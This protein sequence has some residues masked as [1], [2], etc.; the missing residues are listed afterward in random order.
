[1][2]LGGATLVALLRAAVPLAA[3]AAGGLAGCGS[4][5]VQHYYVLTPLAATA[6]ANST[7]ASTGVAIFVDQAHVP[8][9]VDR[10][11]MVIGTGENRVTILEQQRW[12]EPLRAAIAE[13]IALDLARLINGARVTAAQQI[14]IPGDAWRLSL[15]VQRFESRPG[16]AVTVEIAWTLRRGE[17]TTRGAVGDTRSG[18]S[19]ARETVVPAGYDAI[20]VAHSKALATISREIAAVLVNASIPPSRQPAL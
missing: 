1:V 4:V 16:D 9:A 20:A 12:A 14:A 11:Q 2:T 13:V 3:A 6:P 18:R 5:P 10:P 17:D 8:D 19:I 15:D 7:A